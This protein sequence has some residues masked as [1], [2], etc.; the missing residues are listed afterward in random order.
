[1]VHKKLNII[2]VI[3]ARGGSKG[4]IKKN[5]K[6][7]NGKPLI[8]YAIETA[9]E[10]GVLDKIIVSTDCN[11][12]DEICSRYKTIEVIMRPSEL[13]QDTSKTEEALIHVCD[14]LIEKDEFYVD[15]IL[16]L[17]PTSPFRSS[18]TIKKCVNILR[19][20]SVDSVVGVVE[21]KSVL[22]RI[23][24]N[25]FVHIFPNQPR[26]RQ[27]RKGLFQESSTIY[28][29]SVDVLRMKKSVLGDFVYP[30]IIPKNE[31]VDINE[32]IDFE[33]A[34]ILMNKKNK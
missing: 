14:K 18:D 21:V 30:L 23:E 6:L 34:E 16:T 10:S 13:S 19:E 25:K 7:L 12:I 1:M 32:P 15:Y 31:S 28:G 17:E 8:S 4:I 33:I 3:P 24:N 22:G 27:D 11:E 9:L 26:R 20:D 29:T 5:I 2:A